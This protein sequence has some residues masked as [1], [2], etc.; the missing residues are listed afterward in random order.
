M[1]QS[2][3]E[4]QNR[5][6]HVRQVNIPTFLDSNVFNLLHLYIICKKKNKITNEKKKIFPANVCLL[7]GCAH[8]ITCNKKPYLNLMVSSM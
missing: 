4:N 2:L 5:I 3:D 1:Y 7:L 8:I 6:V